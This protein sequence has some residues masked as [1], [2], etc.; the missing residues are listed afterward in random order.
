MRERTQESGPENA[1]SSYTKIMTS[2]AQLL[3][4]TGLMLGTFSSFNFLYGQ[5][6]SNG[7]AAIYAAVISMLVAGVAA[8]MLV[9]GRLSALSTH[10]IAN[11]ESWMESCSA[12]IDS[13]T[14]SA[15]PRALRASVIITAGLSLFLELV[16]IRWEAG[17]F[18]VFALYKN[19]TLLS[20][21]CGLGIGYAKARD[22]QLTLPGSLPMIA[23]LLLI[24]SVLRYGLGDL[25]NAMFQV[26]PVREEASVFFAFDPKAS[27]AA[28][29]IHSLPVYCL[30]ALTFVLNTLVL[31]PVGQFC[32]R[33]MQRM[34]PLAGYGYNLLGSA[35][36]VGLLFVLSWVWAGPAI[37][38]G[39]AAAGLAFFQLGSRAARKI[40][41]GFALGCAMLAA[42]PMTPMVQTIYS[43]Y[44]VIEKAAQPNGLMTLMVSGSY[45]QKVFDLSRANSSRETDRTLQKVIGYY[46]LP[47]QT[48]KSVDR[49]AIVGAGSGNDVASALRNNAGHVDAVEIDPVIRNMGIENHPEH[50]YADPRVH[51]IINDARNFFRTTNASYDAIVYGVLDSHT[52]VS[53]GA[54]M[55]V[56]S[57]VYTKEGLRDAFA[58]L[59][60]GGLFSVSFALPNPLMGEKVFHI[61]KSLPD[62]GQPVAIL[63]G[64]DNNNTTTFMVSKSASVQLP[65]AF[66]K[67]HQLADVTRDYMATS[68]KALDLPTDDW[69]FFYLEKKMYPETY[70]MLLG[71]VLGIA[72]LLVRGLLPL[73]AWQP[74][75][76]SFFFLGGGFMLVETKAITELGLP[77]GNTWQV[78]GVTI[79]SVLV[80]AYLANIFAARLTRNILTLAYLG[81]FAVLLTG[82]A[83]AIHG[84]M[85]ASSLLER[86]LLVAI[87]VGPL[88]FSGV[89]FSTLL[90]GS[91]NISA[92]MAYNLMGAMLGGALEYN[93]MRF[94]FSSLYLIALVLYGLAW[95]TMFFTK[96]PSS[97]RQFAH[98]LSG[99]SRPSEIRGAAVQTATTDL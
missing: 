77:F 55:R 49:V 27:L 96:V 62:A 90:K 50:P 22:K 47:F 63:T 71:L 98:R 40:A 65:L 11:I 30:L 72:F 45:Y 52:V 17:I 1:L 69:P 19:F 43:P 85:A 80:M 41:F 25:G 94:G 78:V 5:F 10:W 31:L 53:H 57:F 93:S 79:I 97:W 6:F 64:Y 7:A 23:L 59:K 73:Q 35:A 67:G 83:V 44:Q 13:W 61:L 89:V 33:L 54:N 4:F 42:W 75:A 99:P 91:K 48:A 86:L 15:S 32:G 9:G 16:L 70:L 8:V 14:D 58:H 56:D 18:V 60:T 82:Y 3:A 26:V 29:F 20:C 84:S 74:S 81:L 46:E 87:L 68:A 28:Y 88:F 38:F 34:E 24:F 76:F 95:L 51:S 37:W 66:M 39:L 2:T 36:G 21:F 92:A 12:E